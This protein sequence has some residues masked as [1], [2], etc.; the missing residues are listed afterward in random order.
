VPLGSD[1]VF[2][3][4]TLTCATLNRLLDGAAL[5]CSERAFGHS[6]G[7]VGLAVAYGLANV[8]AALPFTPGGLGIVE[9]ILAPTLVASKPL[10]ES[11]S[12]AC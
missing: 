1:R 4:Q 3:R 5:W 7:S 12:L 8:T 10:G 11:R 9:G 2:L 6:L